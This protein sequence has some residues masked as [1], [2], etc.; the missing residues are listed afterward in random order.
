MPSEACSEWIHDLS[1]ISESKLINIS[2]VQ[3]QHV[4]LE[5]AVLFL[6]SVAN[7]AACSSLQQPQ[8]GQSE[9]QQQVS[10][11]LK[12]L[13][14]Q[15]LRPTFQQPRLLVLQVNSSPLAHH[16]ICKRC[17]S[18]AQ[19]MHHSTAETFR[20]AQS[21]PAH[22]CPGATRASALKPES[23]A[24]VIGLVTRVSKV[25]WPSR[26]VAIAQGWEQSSNPCEVQQR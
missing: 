15:V 18:K 7:A 5:S 17:C 8:P 2:N 19:S 14:S 25:E 10:T 24:R 22:R 6:G 20:A 11:G 16:E 26:I 23:N 4:Q 21:G 3:D 13:L 1:F 12:Q 9:Q